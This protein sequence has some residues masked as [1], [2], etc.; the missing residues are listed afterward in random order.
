MKK[1]S[2]FTGAE[3]VFFWITVLAMAILP[4][5]NQVK[6]L[7]S[8]GVNDSVNVSVNVIIVDYKTP[9]FTVADSTD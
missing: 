9:V 5:F 4:V 6:T 3:L 8:F 1:N 7:E 2:G